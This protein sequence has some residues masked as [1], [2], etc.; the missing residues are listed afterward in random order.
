MLED[1]KKAIAD[2]LDP[3]TKKLAE[4]EGKAGKFA[5][6]ET[7]IKKI[8]ET[9]LMKR[10][11]NINTIPTEHK[12]RK[13]SRMGCSIREAVA[14]SPYSFGAFRE[15]GKVEE[16]CKWVIDLITAKTALNEGTAAQGAYLVPEEY[17][18]DLIQLARNSS[19]MLNACT[20]VPMGSDTLHIPSEATHGTFTW[21]DEAATKTAS[22]PTFGEVN[23]V[24]KKLFG[25]AVASNEVLQDSLIDIPSIL[26]EQFTYGTAQELDNQVF[27]GTGSPVSGVLTAKAGYSVVLSGASFSTISAVNLSL[28]IEKLE[29][30]YLNGAR[31]F[32]GR[33]QQHYIRSLKDS[34]GAPIYAPVAAQQPATVYG[35]PSNVSETI[36]VT[37]GTTKPVG[38]FGNFKYLVIGRRL[39]Q[40]TLEVDPYTLFAKYQT[41]FR[42]VTRWAFDYGQTGAFCRI[43]AG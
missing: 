38:V 18:A 11:F 24:A 6:I 33:L 13:L 43:I 34:N 16:F 21:E 35:F 28:A 15:E 1:L 31:F 10:A 40:M 7:R 41:Q 3:L 39:G 14:K 20:V 26:T 4:V 25:L 37:D 8:E 32:F 42:M 23:L 5:D 30:G 17:Q 36:A 12:G 19:F 2:M 9:P 29:E 27:E 22:E